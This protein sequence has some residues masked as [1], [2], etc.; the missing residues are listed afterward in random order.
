MRQKIAIIGGGISGLV[1]GHY[2]HS[3][4]DITI[5]EKEDWIGGHS[6]TISVNK[7]L[8]VDTGFIVFNN[9]NYPNFK[10]LLDELGV[11]YQPTEMSFAVRNDEAKL[12]Y[13]GSNLKGLFAD[14]F[15]I[16]GIVRFAVDRDI[17]T[18]YNKN[19]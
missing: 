17:I 4:Y 7:D 8:A 19:L 9:R 14:K 11:Q 16:F 12:E 5:F 18:L 6:H 3:K 13:K 15:N 2:L 1:S 10:K